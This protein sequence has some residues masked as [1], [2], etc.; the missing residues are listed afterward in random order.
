M[1]YAAIANLLKPRPGVKLGE[2]LVLDYE[3]LAEGSGLSIK[4]VRKAVKWLIENRRI[5]AAKVFGNKRKVWLPPNPGIPTTDTPQ[6]LP[7]ES[8]PHTGHEKEDLTE[9]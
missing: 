3:K 6:D 4:Q 5:E 2:T 1:V 7:T 8:F 9:Y